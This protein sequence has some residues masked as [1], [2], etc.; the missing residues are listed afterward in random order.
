MLSGFTSRWMTP[1]SWTAT[2]PSQMASSARNARWS[3]C[4]DELEATCPL[5]LDARDRRDLAEHG[6]LLRGRLEA[7]LPAGQ[8]GEGEPLALR[9]RTE[10]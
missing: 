3:A 1:T 2:I 5:R 8:S 9:E 10:R 6:L 7:G 4:Q